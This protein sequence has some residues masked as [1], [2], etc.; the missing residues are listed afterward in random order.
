MPTIVELSTEPKF[1]IKAVASQTGIRPVTL[2]AWERRHEILSPFRSD[3]HYRL[4]SERD[5]AVLRWLKYRVE[6]GMT[7]S[8]AVNELRSMTRNSVWPEALPQAPKIAPNTIS[9]AAPSIQYSKQLAQALIQHDENR[10]G[11]ILRDIHARFS[12][13]SVCTE[14]LM[15]ATQQIDEAWYRG[16]INAAVERFA[17]AYLRDRLVS[18]LQAYP[19][20]HNAALVL[21]GCAPMEVH[22]L[23]VLMTAVLLRS[24]GY[25]VEYL[26]PDISTE[27]LADY[28]NYVQPSM[29]ILA[30]NS[31]FTARQMRGMQGLLEDV[32]SKPVFAFSGQ[33]FDT[34]PKLRGE[35]PG[36]YLGENLTA[37]LET[38]RGLL[39]NRRKHNH[40]AE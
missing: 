24:E 39:N 22:E 10:A 32:R 29:V 4:Y 23:G 40:R 1:T 36:T 9:T 26:G 15:P 37:A 11:E 27:D 19:S 20:R 35:I 3:N 2:R 38:A 30:A 17:N 31:E 7:I 25:R 6:E 5:V 21:V 33:A 16:E 13:L 34:Q 14:V 28:S 8:N 18:L 12:I